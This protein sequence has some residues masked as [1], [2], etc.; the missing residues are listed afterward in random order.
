M[1]ISQKCKTNIKAVKKKDI[2]LYFIDSKIF[3]L[4]IVWHTQMDTNSPM[5][6]LKKKH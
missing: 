3:I 1:I 4:L 2:I 6:S 5:P